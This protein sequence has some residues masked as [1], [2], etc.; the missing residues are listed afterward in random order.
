MKDLQH[1]AHTDP[2][3]LNALHLPIR[4]PGSCTG[5]ADYFN[6]LDTLEWEDPDMPGK[7]NNGWLYVVRS[8]ELLDVL[9]TSGNTP[10]AAPSI[11]RVSP[12]PSNGPVRDL[13]SCCNDLLVGRGGKHGGVLDEVDYKAV[14]ASF[15][16]SMIGVGWREWVGGKGDAGRRLAPYSFPGD[17]TAA[18]RKFAAWLRRDILPAL[19][20]AW[21]LAFG[22]V[23]CFWQCSQSLCNALHYDTGDA[24]MSQALWWWE[25]SIVGI[26]RGAWFLLP[27]HRYV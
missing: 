16:G 21:V 20:A 24:G 25:N 2:E 18:G 19:I 22:C 14:R 11:L 6:N 26:R 3:A 4:I 5:A 27:N 8:G 17:D 23:A 10:D 13:L 15:G 7:D 1:L 9:T 12:T